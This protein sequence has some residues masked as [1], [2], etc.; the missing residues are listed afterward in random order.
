MCDRECAPFVLSFAVVRIQ[1][2]NAVRIAL[3]LRHPRP[4][5]LN[6]GLRDSENTFYYFPSEKILQAK[7]EYRYACLVA[8]MFSNVSASNRRV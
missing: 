6:P 1:E 3:P 5:N 8:Q 7:E 4:G 2:E